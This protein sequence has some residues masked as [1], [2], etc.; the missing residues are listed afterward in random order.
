[1]TKKTSTTTKNNSIFSTKKSDLERLRQQAKLL[2]LD[3][4]R[5]RLLHE[6]KR[7]VEQEK[8]ITSMFQLGA[9]MGDGK[10]TTDEFFSAFH[11]LVIKL[12]DENSLRIEWLIET[13]RFT[14]SHTDEKHDGLVSNCLCQIEYQIQVCQLK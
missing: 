14:G 9:G 11:S 7:G 2:N 8:I 1:M 3:G 4:E 5:V 13:F 10:K 12:A 6:G